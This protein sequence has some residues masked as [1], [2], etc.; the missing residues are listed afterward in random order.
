MRRRIALA[1]AMYGNDIDAQFGG[2]SEFSRWSTERKRRMR[3]LIAERDGSWTCHWCKRP[4]DQDSSVD[5]EL[6]A[7]L[8][9]L[10]RQCEGGG[11]ESSNLVLAC[12][13][14][15]SQR[16]NKP[17]HPWYKGQP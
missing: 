4:V 11:S 8:D 16:H 13:R 7:T 10:V 9:H 17:D 5:N 1:R 3:D 2:K 6:F 14:C 12:R 15:N